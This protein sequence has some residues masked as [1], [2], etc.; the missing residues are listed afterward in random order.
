MLLLLFSFCSMLLFIIN[1]ASNNMWYATILLQEYNTYLYIYI[2]VCLHLRVHFLHIWIYSTLVVT[3]N[4]LLIVCTDSMAFGT[5]YIVV[6]PTSI[7]ICEKEEAV[8]FVWKPW[9]RNGWQ[10]EKDHHRGGVGDTDGRICRCGG[11]WVLYVCFFLPCRRLSSWYT[12][13]SDTQNRT[14]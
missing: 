5:H 8:S 11:R 1:T 6:W 12:D 7:P 13:N 3:L 9:N 2:N 10:E 4:L 14:Y